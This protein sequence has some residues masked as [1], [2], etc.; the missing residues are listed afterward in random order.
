[1][2]PHPRFPAF[3][4]RFG[5]WTRLLPILKSVVGPVLDTVF[6]KWLDVL[7]AQYTLRTPYHNNVHAAAYGLIWLAASGAPVSAVL[8]YLFHDAGHNGNAKLSPES[9]SA[10]KAREVLG[11]DDLRVAIMHTV[12]PYV[13][14]MNGAPSDWPQKKAE[15]V[16]GAWIRQADTLRPSLGAV[17]P[18]LDDERA[19]S[20]DVYLYE[21]LGLHCELY[22][23]D[24]RTTFPQWIINGQCGFF[25][26]Q[27]DLGL[28]A[29]AFG[30]IVDV[31][32]AHA[33]IEVS[34]SW[35]KAVVADKNKFAVLCEL[36][37]Y[38]NRDITLCE[39]VAKRQELGL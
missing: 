39:F 3:E 38:F 19:T 36:G 8:A 24:G 21:S 1:M 25:P 32:A 23:V 22:E 35:L 34:R 2:N 27:L 37:R 20:V 33:G 29:G 28:D 30:D 15:T 9:L 7:A 18:Y 31:A 14:G 6:P 10:D 26:G 12:F 11:H 4:G 16:D 13:S 5:E 17:Q